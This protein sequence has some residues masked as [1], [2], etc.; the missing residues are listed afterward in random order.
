MQGIFITEVSSVIPPES[1][2]TPIELLR[3]K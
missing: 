1:V 3:H 2:I